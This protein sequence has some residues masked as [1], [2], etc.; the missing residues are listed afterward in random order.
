MKY[1]NIQILFQTPFDLETTGRGNIFQIDAAERTRDQFDGADDL[2]GIFGP[3]ADG[4]R[5]HAAVRLEQGAF[6]F[7]DGHTR[8]GTDIAEP[9]NGGAVCD[10]RNGIPAA[11]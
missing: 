2:F 8:F 9:Q 7:H 1:G 10:H 5:I 6:A 11:R 4:E 3:Q